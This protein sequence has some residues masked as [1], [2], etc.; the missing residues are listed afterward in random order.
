MG[1]FVCQGNLRHTSGQVFPKYF[2]THKS[3]S[4]ILHTVKRRFLS[5]ATIYEMTKHIDIRKK[6][7]IVAVGKIDKKALWKEAI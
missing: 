6:L 3:T 4:L 2:L 7:P 1:V 5:T